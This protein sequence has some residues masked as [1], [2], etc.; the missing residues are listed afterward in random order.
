MAREVIKAELK[1]P[2]YITLSNCVTLRIEK[3]GETSEDSPY[4]DIRTVNDNDEFV[5]YV[6]THSHVQIRVAGNE[7]Y[8]G[9]KHPALRGIRGKPPYGI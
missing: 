6:R 5:Y 1:K 4:I 3:V 9:K 7:P 2:I 8:G